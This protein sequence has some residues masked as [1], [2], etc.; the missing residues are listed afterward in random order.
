MRVSITPLSH[1][2]SCMPSRWAGLG[3]RLRAGS[4][5]WLRWAG[6]EWRVEWIEKGKSEEEELNKRKKKE[7]E[8]V[9]MLAREN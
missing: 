4:C 8:E 3:L 2:A 9:E 1:I 5:G 6:V 7:E